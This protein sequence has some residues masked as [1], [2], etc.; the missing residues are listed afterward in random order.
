MGDHAKLI[1][2][3]IIENRVHSS[4]SDI[5]AT[6]IIAALNAAGLVIVPREPT[7]VMLNEAG[8]LL[9]PDLVMIYQAMIQV[10]GGDDD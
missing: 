3:A 1:A 6:S 8:K 7:N 10:A 9:W 2:R 4:P 5:E